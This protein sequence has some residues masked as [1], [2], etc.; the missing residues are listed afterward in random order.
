MVNGPL[1]GAGATRTPYRTREPLGPV[2]QAPRTW[3]WR[4]PT[5]RTA[6]RGGRIPAGGARVT[7]AIMPQPG[8]VPRDGVTSPCCGRGSVTLRSFSCRSA[9]GGDGT[10][11]STGH[12]DH[13]SAAASMV[14]RRAELAARPPQPGPT[15]HQSRTR[16]RN[17]H[18]RRFRHI[19]AVDPRCVVDRLHSSATCQVRKRPACAAA[20]YR[21]HDSTLT[22][23]RSSLGSSAVSACR[24]STGD[25]A[26]RLVW[27][28]ARSER[29]RP[30]IASASSRRLLT[31]RG[32]PQYV[33]GTV[34]LGVPD[35]GV[36]PGPRRVGLRCYGTDW[37]I[38]AASW[39]LRRCAVAQPPVPGR[40]VTGT[41]VSGGHLA[42]NHIQIVIVRLL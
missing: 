12:T 5:I 20:D 39:R 30:G 22:P 27:L 28:C 3:G 7:L 14:R 15:C 24:P 26:A 21:S 34:R 16:C 29:W 18:I 35:A 19:S 4:C 31:V 1:Y 6:G 17:R 13:R 41:W 11:S 40:D 2:P 9:G 38:R 8:P 42:A 10:G 23:R 37:P 25:T 33:P 32:R 36:G